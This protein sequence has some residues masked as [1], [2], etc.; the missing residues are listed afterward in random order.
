M[1]ETIQFPKRGPGRPRR[2]TSTWQVMELRNQGWSFRRIAKAMGL[3]Y[4]TVR[5]AYAGGAVTVAAASREPAAA[6]RSMAAG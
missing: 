1:P 6:A 4:G 2:N 3:G 5:R